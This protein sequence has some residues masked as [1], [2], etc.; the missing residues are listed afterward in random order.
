MRE[1]TLRGLA[2]MIFI[3]AWAQSSAAAILIEPSSLK[4][5]F[6]NG[7]KQVKQF[8]ITNN[9]DAEMVLHV[10]PE[11]WSRGECREEAKSWVVPSPEN[12]TIPAHQKQV[13]QLSIATP[14][15][16][17]GECMVMVYLAQKPVGQNIA[18]QARIG[19]PVY[20]LCRDTGITRGEILSFE[21]RASDLS[22]LSFDADVKNTGNIHVLPFGSLILQDK[23]NGKIYHQ[24]IQFEQ[25]IFPGQ[26]RQVDV[27]FASGSV[28]AG[29]Y[30]AKLELLL[31]DLYARDGHGLP[32]LSRELDVTVGKP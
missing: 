25:P 6:P 27:L 19:F 12:L 31:D 18:I 22:G 32:A 14:S 24:S 15:D 23:T 16:L 20:L 13:L 5:E 21:Q 11:F 17:N 28:P 26:S 8:V 2:L 4:L 1:A 9:S 7:T 3:G 30:Q 10:E 29:R